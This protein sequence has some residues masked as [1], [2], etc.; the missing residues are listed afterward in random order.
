MDNY[1]QEFQL[2]DNILHVR[3]SGKFPEGI[4]NTNN[5]VF[6]QLIDECNNK[7][8]TK[9]IIDICDLDINLNL[10]ELFK[11]GEDAALLSRQGL[12]MALVARKETIDSFFYDV[13]YNRGGMV[14]VFNDKGAALEWLQN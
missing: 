14:N 2:I 7:S 8:I 4:M 1:H 6:Q 9:T 5:N 3:L 12:N 13:A 10:M 11:A